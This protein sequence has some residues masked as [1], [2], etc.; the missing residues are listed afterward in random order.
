MTYRA[1][2]NDG[3]TA[4]SHDVYV[5][6]GLAGLHL[7]DAEGRRLGE[8][9]Y[10]SLRR[11][12]ASGD[13]KVLR[14]KSLD[15]ESERL[16]FDSPDILT[17]MAARGCNVPYEEN[18]SLGA[19]ARTAIL[20]TVGTVLLVIVVWFGFPYA[21]RVAAALIPLSWERALGDQAYIQIIELFE[22]LGEEKLQVC[23]EQ[24]GQE[25]VDKLVA[26]F[27]ATS[28][29][30]YDYRVEVVDIPVVN[31]FA[32][33]GGRIVF[34]SELVEKA[35]TPAEFAGVLAHEMG[36]VVHRD[37]T[38]AMMR[39]YALSI[40]IGFVTGDFSGGT[41]GELG[42]LVLEM[43]YSRDAEAEADQFAAEL[44]R[45]E[46]ITSAGMVDFF[47]RINE[48]TGDM[49]RALRF[50]SSHPPHEE[51][52]DFFR[53]S[54]T[55]TGPG[56]TESEWAALQKICGEREETEADPEDETG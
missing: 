10:D 36:H 17:E 4:L 7:E 27:A 20:G 26:D 38:Q 37:G 55:G 43:S 15:H 6:P 24:P 31:A 56:L 25:V 52:I 5:K 12:E 2:Y 54:E 18:Q 19:V 48:E 44:L 40:V 16:I 3:K 11:L 9:R 22:F 50:L 35:T 34:F 32:L 49:P 47:S 21:T 45:E 8:W 1:R 30:P 23:R 53:T 13:S 14:L 51:R 33:P 42:Q 46:G 41:L 29:S 39:N 28:K